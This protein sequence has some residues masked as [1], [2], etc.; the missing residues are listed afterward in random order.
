MAVVEG[1]NVV[2]LV[3][4]VQTGPDDFLA[5]ATDGEVTIEAVPGGGP[6]LA[7]GLAYSASVFPIPWSGASYTLSPTIPV[8][9]GIT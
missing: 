7:L 8:L 5:I 4:P 2:N 9:H 1:R 6:A 3:A